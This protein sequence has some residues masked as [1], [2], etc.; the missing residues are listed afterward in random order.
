ML[1]TLHIWVGLEVQD[2][3]FV[4]DHSYSKANLEFAKNPELAFVL[5]EN[6]YAEKPKQ[7]VFVKTEG[8]FYLPETGTHP[9]KIK[10]KIEKFL[11][12]GTEDTVFHFS[13]H[14]HMVINII[15]DMV[16]L[17]TIGYEKVFIH[18]MNDDN[19]HIEQEASFNKEGYLENWEAGTLSY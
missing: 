13:T 14:S 17:G 19:S 7:K 11:K 1:K 9:R 8:Y 15:G 12:Y 5:A 3:T 10:E 4:N 18:V 6:G 2:L 16:E